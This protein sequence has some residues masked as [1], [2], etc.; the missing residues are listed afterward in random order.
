MSDVASPL[1]WVASTTMLSSFNGDCMQWQPTPEER[2]SIEAETFWMFASL[3][4]D[5]MAGN[6]SSDCV[7]MHTQLAALARLLLI[8]DAPLHDHLKR[9]DALN[10]FFCYRWVLILFKREFSF[11]K[12]LRLWEAL[13]AHPGD[14]FLLYVCVAVLERQ[15]RRILDEDLDFDGLL[16]LCVDLA[17]HIDLEQTL[18]DAEM[19]REFAGEAGH[20]AVIGDGKEV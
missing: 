1:L 14:N 8:L 11:D 15:R 12:V 9:H 3:M 4:D 5:G 17:G 13:W 16:K 20:V 6:F 18:A 10:L 2:T 19:L 7:G